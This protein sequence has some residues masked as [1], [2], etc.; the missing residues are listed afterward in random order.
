M[1][2]S[3]LTRRT[4]AMER[5][6]SHNDAAHGCYQ[7]SAENYNKVQTCENIVQ[8]ARGGC[9]SRRASSSASSLAIGVRRRETVRGRL[10][11]KACK[12]VPRIIIG[13]ARSSA[14][15]VAHEACEQP[16]PHG[17]FNHWLRCLTE[18]N[19]E[20][21]IHPAW[22]AVRCEHR[23]RASEGRHAGPPRART[24][25]DCWSHGASTRRVRQR[26]PRC[27]PSDAG[28]GPARGCCHHRRG[29]RA[30]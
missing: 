13:A 28:L 21:G 14:L 1:A 24:G 5:S 11:G 3:G 16:S 30:C 23:T 17:K 20:R 7:Q 25:G 10:F 22:R 18:K 19:L 12:A 9:A 27:P 4:M 15:A 29:G 8:S 2:S 6:Q 26:S